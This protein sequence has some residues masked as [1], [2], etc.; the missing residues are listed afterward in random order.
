MEFYYGIYSGCGTILFYIKYLDQTF[1]IRF[2]YPRHNASVSFLVVR[3]LIAMIKTNFSLNSR[4]MKYFGFSF[5]H[6]SMQ[7]FDIPR[8]FLDLPPTYIWRIVDCIKLTTKKG[9]KWH[10]LKIFIDLIWSIIFNVLQIVS[11]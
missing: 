1:E 2:P 6:F 11:L 10:I 7:Q 8:I 5:F 4:Y 9:T 3:N